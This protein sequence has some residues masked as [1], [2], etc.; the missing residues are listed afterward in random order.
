M[1]QRVHV[2]DSGARPGATAHRLPGSTPTAMC[3]PWGVFL[4]QDELARISSVKPLTAL[5]TLT[6]GMAECAPTDGDYY[7]ARF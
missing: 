4:N 3:L 6:V 1:L 7:T 5:L 2:A